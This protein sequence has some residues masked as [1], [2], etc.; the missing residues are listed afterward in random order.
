LT[1]SR[2]DAADPISAAP[3]TNTMSR[4]CGAPVT[5]RACSASERPAST[6]N[7]C[8]R[9][10]SSRGNVAMKIVYWRS[11]AITAR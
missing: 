5:P 1:S 9:A 2:I 8:D 11:A 10:A 6:G 7:A 3:T 4:L